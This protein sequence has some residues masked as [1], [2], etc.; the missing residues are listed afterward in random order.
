MV[1]STRSF[2]LLMSFLRS[3]ALVGLHPSRALFLSLELPDTEDSVLRRAWQGVLKLFF[4]IHACTIS[5]LFH[6][7]SYI[8]IQVGNTSLS[9]SAF[10]RIFLLLVNLPAGMSRIP[11][12]DSETSD[13]P[14]FF[15]LPNSDLR[16]PKNLKKHRKF[17]EAFHEVGSHEDNHF[18]TLPLSVCAECSCR[19]NAST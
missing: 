1:S 4:R 18:V 2:L 5:Q 7:F 11:T 10:S 17:S 16:F 3:S 12:S 8:A 9:I 13:I 6:Q 14:V 15:A 19:T